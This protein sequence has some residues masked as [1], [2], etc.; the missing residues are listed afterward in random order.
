MMKLYLTN[1]PSWGFE[2]IYFKSRHSAL[3]K[4]H[5]FGSQCLIHLDVWLQARLLTDIDARVRSGPGLTL[6]AKET[7]DHRTTD[8]RPNLLSVVA[9][10]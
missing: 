3:N 5:A 6:S 7:A 1:P 9:M 8:Q 2:D 4:S 10:L